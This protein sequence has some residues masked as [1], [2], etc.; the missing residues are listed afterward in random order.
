MNRSTLL[1]ISIVVA[2]LFRLMTALNPSLGMFNFSPLMA[3]AFCAGSLVLTSRRYQ[4]FTVAILI[5]TDLTLNSIHG[6]SGWHSFM[7]LTSLCYLSVLFLGTKLQKSSFPVQSGGL[8]ASS[9]LFYFATNTLTWIGSPHYTQNFSGWV[10][11]WTVGIEGF[12]PTYLFLRNSLLSDLS[13]FL[14]LKVFSFR[15]PIS[16]TVQENRSPVSS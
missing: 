6:Y 4:G 2:S 9:L 12:P 10:Q 15:F 11:S 13:F 1:F 16:S 7:V 8:I 14:I 3:L 5:V